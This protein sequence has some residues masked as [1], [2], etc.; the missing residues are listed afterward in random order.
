MFF[1]PNLYFEKIISIKISIKSS[2]NNLLKL[3]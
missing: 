3:F 1:L 2:K